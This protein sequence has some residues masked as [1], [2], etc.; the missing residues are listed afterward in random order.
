MEKSI[1]EFGGLPVGIAINEGS[2][3]RFIAV[4]FHVIDLDNQRF[5]SL[6]DL[7]RAILRHVGDN[8]QLAALRPAG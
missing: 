8:S 4:K 5:S 1:V 2:V 6:G 3:F 7:R